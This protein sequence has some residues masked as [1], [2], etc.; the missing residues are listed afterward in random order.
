MTNIEHLVEN[1]LSLLEENI[2][3]SEWRDTM[4]DDINWNPEISMTLSELWII[5]QYIN[6]RDF[7]KENFIITITGYKDG[8][9]ECERKTHD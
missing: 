2:S 1:G 3:Y 8:R 7:Y 5:C 4:F 6:E 9:I